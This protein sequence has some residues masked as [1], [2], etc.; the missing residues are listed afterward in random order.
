MTPEER[1]VI[2]EK[3]IDSLSRENYRFKQDQKRV[4]DIKSIIPHD[5]WYVAYLQSEIARLELQ[6]EEGQKN[7]NTYQK[8]YSKWGHFYTRYE[9]ERLCNTH[10][11]SNPT[12]ADRSSEGYPQSEEKKEEGVI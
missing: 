8:H 11:P 5:R 7:L 10:T 2:L 6:Y 12:D 4:H 9:N 1:I 3:R